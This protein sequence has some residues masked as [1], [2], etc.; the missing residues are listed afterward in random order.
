MARHVNT[1]NARSAHY[2][3]SIFNPRIYIYKF[4]INFLEIS[5]DVGFVIFKKYLP[6]FESVLGSNK[7]LELG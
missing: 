4:A 1:R 5:G 2:F 6:N 7:N 3:Y